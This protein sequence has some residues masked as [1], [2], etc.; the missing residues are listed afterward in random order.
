MTYPVFA[1]KWAP[2]DQATEEAISELAQHL[3]K[4]KKH[5]KNDSRNRR[6][7]AAVLAYRGRPFEVRL[8]SLPKDDKEAVR[9]AINCLQG[10]VLLTCKGVSTYELRGEVVPGETR[11]RTISTDTTTVPVTTKYGAVYTDGTI[12]EVPMA[13]IRLIAYAR[14]SLVRI[15]SPH[16]HWHMF[17]DGLSV[18][19]YNWRDLLEH[20]DPHPAHDQVMNAVVANA[21]HYGHPIVR[22]GYDGFLCANPDAVVFQIDNTLLRQTGTVGQKPLLHVTDMYGRHHERWGTANRHAA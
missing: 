1:L 2:I 22:Y 9:D 4:R 7:L 15:V 16:H 14:P 19:S 3:D 10:E 21:S 5:L 6:I 12:G 20:D 17:F 8:S 18:P 11:V 13:D